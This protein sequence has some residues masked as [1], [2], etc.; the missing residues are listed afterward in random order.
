[1]IQF[2]SL[3]LKQLLGYLVLNHRVRTGAE[4]I[5]YLLGIMYNKLDYLSILGFYPFWLKSNE[6][7]FLLNSSPSLGFSLLIRDAHSLVNEDLLE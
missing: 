3:R 1:M 2:S 4:S 5:G 7:P 6:L